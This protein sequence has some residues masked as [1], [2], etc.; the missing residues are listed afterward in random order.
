MSTEILNDPT[1]EAKIYKC[2]PVDFLWIPL[3]YRKLLGVITM[4]LFSWTFFVVPIS[5]LIL[6][7]IYWTGINTF[8]LVWF[9]IITISMVIPSREWLAFRKLGQLWY[10]LLDVHCTHDPNNMEEIIRIASDKQYIL[11]MHPHGV[12]PFQSILWA[13]Y[14]GQYMAPLYGFG[15]GADITLWLPILRNIMGWLSA[16]SAS[17]KPLRDGLMYGKVPCVTSRKPRNL[18]ILPGGIAEVFTSAPGVHK[19]VFKSRKGLM[20][21]ALETGAVLTPVYVFGGTDFFENLSTSKSLLSKLCR[22]FRI[23]ITIFW[24]WCY[25]PIPYFPKI[26]M[27]ISEDIIVDKWNSEKGPVPKELIDSLHSRYI[28]AIQN[29]FNKYKVIAGYPNSQLEIV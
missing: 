12:I 15:A 16:G 7:S 11:A 4:I 5:I 13:A 9:S 22:H 26:T 21:L 28:E 1:Q 3:F 10:E 17:Y 23:A 19:I 20:K 24:G 25:L 14:C 2:V 29:L 8:V 27:V 6:M 18:Y